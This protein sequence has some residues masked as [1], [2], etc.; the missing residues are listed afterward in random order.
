MRFYLPEVLS[1]SRVTIA[2][3]GIVLKPVVRQILIKKAT[4][5]PTDVSLLD[6]EDQSDVVMMVMIIK[7]QIVLNV[8]IIVTVVLIVAIEYIEVSLHD[9]KI[10][11]D[12][13]CF[14]SN[15][16]KFAPGR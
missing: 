4:I 15:Y 11:T 6:D 9:I 3:Y 10:K 13:L 5:L 16:I 12:L 14:Y 1:I 7:D 8:V 2:S